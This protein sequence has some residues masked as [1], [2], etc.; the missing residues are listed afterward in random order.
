MEWI[1]IK[2]QTPPKDGTRILGARWNKH[3]NVWDIGV[4]KWTDGT[5][6][7]VPTRDY[8]LSLL[9][10]HWAELKEPT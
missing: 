1:S 9:P 7:V 10:T 4:I 8:R 3:F 2:E 6:A 5:F